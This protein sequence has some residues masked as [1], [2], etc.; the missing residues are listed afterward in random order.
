[1]AYEVKRVLSLPSLVSPSLNILGPRGGGEEGANKS[2]SNEWDNMR[3]RLMAATLRT[4]K[5]E[6]QIDQEWML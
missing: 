5:G 3:S 6:P 1:M 2:S 4:L